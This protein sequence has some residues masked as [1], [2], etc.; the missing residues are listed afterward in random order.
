MKTRI[1]AAVVLLPLLLV[2]LFVLPTVWTA[3]LCSAAVALAAYELL[4]STGLVK[5]IRLIAYTA[6]MAFLVPLWS[7]FG[8]SY[9]AALIA[10]LAFVSLLYGE[11]LISKATLQYEKMM[12][13]LAGGLLIP[14]MLSALVRIHSGAEGRF[15]IPVPFIMAFL[16]DSG[17]YFAG[18]FLGRHK[19]APTIS[20]KKTVEGAVGGV[21][22]G[23]A[24]M[25]VYCLVLSKCF[26]FTVNYWYAL[27]YGVLGALA[28]MFGDLSFSAI[29]RQNGIKDY[30]NLIPGHGG[31][32]DRFDSMTLVAPL[33]EILL[34]LLPIAVR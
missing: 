18:C 22:G 6:V 19:L 16:S 21:L 13:C 29:K 11:E 2:F 33:A 17:A 24:G 20:P 12:T 1:I 28:A 32:L 26:S 27:V 30:G 3:V 4:W 23:I 14:F 25:L 5:N 7:W 31:V 15:L 34:I 9:V 10:V 8:M